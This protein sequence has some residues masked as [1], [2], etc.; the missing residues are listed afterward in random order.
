MPLINTQEINLLMQN[1]QLYLK[2]WLL[3]LAV[4]WGLNLANWLTGSRLNK[5]GIYPRQ[6]AGLMGI[7]LCP[8]LH[9]NVNHLLLNSVPLF[10]LVLALLITK[11]AMATIWLT[12]AITLIGGFGVWLV[13]RPG[14]HIGASGLI[15]GYFGYIL[16]IA[17]IRPSV[18]TVLTAFVA[19][20]YF[21]SLFF[22]IFPGKKDTSWESH[23]FG[24]LAG[25]LCAYYPLY[26]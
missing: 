20:Y 10:F 21:G 14:S 8:V 11:G 7:P 15:S 12:L 19:L 26:W 5:Y 13:A 4:L 18:I 25:M 2:P 16:V 6:S 3:V 17:Y 9:C 22:G 23:L 1:A 24:F